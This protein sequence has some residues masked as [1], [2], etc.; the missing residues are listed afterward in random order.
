M[1]RIAGVVGWPVDHSLSPLIHNHWLE[2][3][4]IHD[5]EYH[6][7][8]VEPSQFGEWIQQLRGGNF[9]GVNLTIPHKELV[10][11]F[12]DKVDETAQRIGAVNTVAV[13]D[14]KLYGYNTDAYGFMTN[15]KEQSVYKTHTAFVIGAGGAARAVVAGLIEDGFSRIV[16][17]NRTREKAEA[18]LPFGEAIEVV[19]WNESPPELAHADLLVN[20]T[21]LGMKHQPP[22]VVNLEMLPA[23][24]LVTDIVYSPLETDLLLQAKSRNLATVDGLGMLLYQA[25]KAFEIWFGV[26]P[27][28]D[29]A[30]REL[31]L[32]KRGGG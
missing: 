8:P 24:A 12:L 32:A 26:L 14:G 13:M 18:F 29:N 31:V 25:Q 17:M 21:A 3:S 27:D 20:T 7:L 6:H 16:M 1:K 2:Q 30:L 9:V 5:V 15:L 4:G 28:V 10:I 19:D 23:H 22:L 11:P